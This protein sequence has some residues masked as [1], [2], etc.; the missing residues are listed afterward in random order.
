MFVKSLVGTLALTIPLLGVADI[1]V[2]CVDPCVAVTTTAPT[3]GLG[4]LVTVTVIGI[5]VTVQFTVDGNA[6][7]AVVVTSS[8]T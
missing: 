3:D 5:L 7:I 8:V 1:S 2:T 6:D 4:L